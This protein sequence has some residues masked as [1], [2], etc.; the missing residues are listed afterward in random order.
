MKCMIYS[1]KYEAILNIMGAVPD[2]EGMEECSLYL[3]CLLGAARP[4]AFLGGQIDETRFLDEV[5][6]FFLF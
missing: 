3:I 2:R 5:K 4:F 1:P 6:A